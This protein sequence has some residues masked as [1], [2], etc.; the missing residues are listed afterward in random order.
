MVV[1]DWL[2][3][4]TSYYPKFLEKY[5]SDYPAHVPLSHYKSKTDLLKGLETE[6]SARAKIID[7]VM[8]NIDWNLFWA[9]YSESDH[10][11]HKCHDDLWRGDEKALKLFRTF[12]ETIKKSSELADLTIVLSDHGFSRFRYFLNINSFLN[13]LGLVTK[14][15]K[16]TM[17]EFTDFEI[18]ITTERV[19]MPQ[20]I[21]KIV[22]IKPIKAIV[23]KIFKVIGGKDIKAELPYVNPVTSRAFM[24]SNMSLGIHVKDKLLTE[25]IIRKLKELNGISNVWKREEIYSGPFVKNAPEILFLPDFGHGYRIGTIMLHPKIVIERTDFWHH[26]DGMIAIYGQGVTPSWVGTVEAFDVVPTILKYMG[27]PLPNDTDGKLIP[28]IN[29]PKEHLKCHRYLKHWR[30]IRQAQI[31]RAALRRKLKHQ[32]H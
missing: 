9:V 11:L 14:T 23:K 7:T 30:L 27:L 26:P 24:S 20:K 16:K 19:R 15:W 13:K 6:A 10:V 5:V 18:D 8:E 31:K 4:K 29:Y 17:K 12:D 21:Y 28:N 32:K 1:S 25:L 22:S 3:P 2:A